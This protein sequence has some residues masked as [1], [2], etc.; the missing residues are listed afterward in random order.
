LSANQWW[1]TVDGVTRT[2]VVT[3]SAS[4][5]GA[6]TLR[7]LQAGGGRVVGVDRQDAD[8]VADLATRAGRLDAA[9]AVGKAVGGRLDAVVACA[10]M[11]AENDL[12]VRVNYFGVVD[13]V[14][15]LQPLLAK[16]DAPGVAVVSSAAIDHR[17]DDAMVAACLA[18]DEEAAAAAANAAPRMAYASGKRALALWVRREAPTA[19]WAGAGITLNGVAP[20]TIVTPMS[21]TA[22]DHPKG[23][24]RL[25]KLIP[26][27]LGGHGRPEQVAALLGWLAG[28]D[29]TL[30]TGQ[31]VFV[32]GGADAL[33]RPGDIWAH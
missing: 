3:G 6:A 15:A 17:C 4:G 28:P 26:M 27:P 21:A 33:L 30:V 14:E 16:G 29:N 24:A 13:L 31:V 11:W 12:P 7:Q 10:G 19:A 22:L 1:I 25:D 23:A 18:G 5:I 9:A 20:G 2:S 32:D 8:V